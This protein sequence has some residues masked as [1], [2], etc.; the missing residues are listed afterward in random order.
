[1]GVVSADFG[2]K[3]EE[4]TKEAHDHF[5]GLY[6]DIASMFGSTV[7]T[8]MGEIFRGMNFAKGV[9]W[10]HGINFKKFFGQVFGGVKDAFFKM[11][12]E[13]VTE[14]VLGLF[15]SFF[16][17]AAKA[18]TDAMAGAAKTAVS[19]ASD[20]VK[21]AAGA[22]SGLW[23]GVG[24]AVGT[25]LGTLLGGGKMNTSDITYWLKIIW[26]NSEI[27][28][29]FVSDNFNGMIHEL[30]VGKNRIVDQL[31]G[32]SPLMD[33]TNRWLESI[34]QNTRPLLNMKSAAGG[35]DM[36]AARPQIIAVHAQERVTVTPAATAVNVQPGQT[37]IQL[38]G[39]TIALAIA[40]YLT[41]LQRAGV[42]KTASSSLVSY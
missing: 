4:V 22:I 38:D 8:F 19:G 17:S 16:S 7:S 5:A 39:R 36:I 31:D 2:K 37:I 9:F 32:R 28:K 25:F 20:I 35:L 10:E 15:K 30:V 13:M 23:T 33:A 41:E 6:N 14:K 12:G 34:E 24:A 21:G 11:V 42:A 27:I 1:L 18:G 40:P 29:N 26:E 3:T